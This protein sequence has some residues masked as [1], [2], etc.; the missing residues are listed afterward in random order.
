M[1]KPLNY[2]QKEVNSELNKLNQNFRNFR[3]K[4]F[5]I[6]HN[7]KTLEN[8]FRAYDEYMKNKTVDENLFTDYK[9]LQVKIQD[10]L[11]KASGH[12]IEENSLVWDIIRDTRDHFDATS[13]FWGIKRISLI[14][15]IK[16]PEY[17]HALMESDTYFDN[18][19]SDQ[20]FSNRKLWIEICNTIDQFI[21]YTVEKFP[22]WNSMKKPEKN[23]YIKYIEDLSVAPFLNDSQ[24]LTL[25]VQF[26]KKY[27][28]NQS[29]LAKARL[30][31][32]F[33]FPNIKTEKTA[34][35]LVEFTNLLIYSKTTK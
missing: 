24:K 14:N 33:K 3:V 17:S 9:D 2:Y 32:Q 16:H 27:G 11:F 7:A 8:L 6:D 35:E 34:L 22:N 10:Y 13:K 28:L 15:K 20:Y 21:Q 18:P 5:E 12:Q 29:K 30:L 25:Y 23:R 19:L 31:L 4:D 1:A 26:L